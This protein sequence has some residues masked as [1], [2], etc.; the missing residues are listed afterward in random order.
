MNTIPDE[1]KVVN[2]IYQSFILSA[3]SVG[4]AMLLKKVC[5]MK[6][7]TIDKIEMEDLLKF[8]GIVSMANFTDEWLYSKGYIPRD[9]MK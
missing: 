9:I 5:K 6:M 3:T 7:F 4:Y 1:K 2:T 8:G